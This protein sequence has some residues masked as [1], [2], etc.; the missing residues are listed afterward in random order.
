M[1]KLLIDIVLGTVFFGAFYVGF[2]M[3]ASNAYV[4]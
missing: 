4:H 1:K 2:Y 3:L